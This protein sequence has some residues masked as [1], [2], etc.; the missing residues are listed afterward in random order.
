M[1]SF[2]ERSGVHKWCEGT[3]LS[4]NLDRSNKISHP[5]YDS[6]G[7]VG[8]NEYFFLETFPEPSAWFER[9]QSY[10]KSVAASSIVGYIM[11]LGDR[12]VNNI[13]IDKNTAEV[14]HIDFGIAF[15]KGKILAT[16]ETVPFRLTRDIVDGMGINGVE[17]TFK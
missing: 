10:I 13:L 14:V 6:S 9:R 3:A 16:P 1:S 7:Y 12:H 17:G 5:F 11:G 4:H 8:K 2:V 15:E